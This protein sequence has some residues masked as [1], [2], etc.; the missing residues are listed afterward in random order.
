MPF[1]IFGKKDKPP[2]TEEAINSLRTTE[3]MLSKKSEHI[4]SQME[5]EIKLAKQ[6][7][8]KN[9]R[10]A[11]QHLKK[12]KRLEQQLQQVDNT[13]VGLLVS[14]LGENHAA[15]LKNSGFSRFFFD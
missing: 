12:K 11:L 7:G 15:F 6:Y 4:E 8:T 10:Q 2:T 9:K 13:G 14:L 3:E 1:N 5:K